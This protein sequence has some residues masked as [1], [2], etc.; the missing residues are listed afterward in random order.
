VWDT[1]VAPDDGLTARVDLRDP[2]AVAVAI[3]RFR[4]ALVYHLAAASSVARSW[5]EP[6]RCFDVNAGGTA[7]LLTAVGALDPPPLVV[8]ATSGEIYGAT[9]PER[10][11]REPDA[12]QPV[13]PYGLSKAAQDA[14]VA[15]AAVPAVRMRPFL[16]TGPG[17]PDLF[18]LPSFARGIAE[19]EAG[20]RPPRLEVGNLDAVRDVSD[21]RDVVR[22]YRL[23]ADRS[24]AGEAFNVASGIGHPIGR[25]LEILLG[26]ARCPMEVTPDPGRLRPSDLPH[27][28]GDASSLREATGWAPGIPVERTLEDVLEWWRE[29]IAHPGGSR[30]GANA[31][32]DR[33]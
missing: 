1:P 15:G 11:A 8:A 22:A 27:L 20:L 14:L 6:A 25:L 31:G 9:R 28:V 24:L 7:N 23:V 19:A 10:P 32:G 3:E 13:S 30:A 16:H 29:R 2:I 26:M 4:P 33:S 17:Q 21:V 12:V 18:A 5:R